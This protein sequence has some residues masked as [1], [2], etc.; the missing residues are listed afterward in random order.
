MVAP[1]L[2]A[3]VVTAVVSGLGF[4]ALYGGAS[5]RVAALAVARPVAAGAT[6]APGDL[7]EVELS[8]GPGVAIVAASRRGEMIGRRTAVALT[9]GSLLN[10]AQ[11]ANQLELE[12]GQV[13]AAVALKAGQYPPELAAGDSVL[14]VATSAPAGSAGSVGGT[15]LAEQARVSGLRI[16]SGPGGQAAVVSLVVDRTLAPD[17]VVAASAGQ[18]GLALAG[19][20]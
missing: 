2:L 20:R 11:F 8:R 14:V 18:V 15:V 7:R 10:E 1:L 6:I 13:V 5:D 16:G 12:P 17:L 9:P 19:G 4:A 3:G